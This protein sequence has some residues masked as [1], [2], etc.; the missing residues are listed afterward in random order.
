MKASKIFFLTFGLALGLVLFLSSV[1]ASGLPPEEPI[2][3][4]CSDI[5][6]CSS[7]CTKTCLDDFDGLSTCGA[8]GELCIDS[9][10]CNPCGCSVYRYGTSGPDTIHGGSNNDCIW[11]YED[12]DTLFGEAG[13]D[14][15]Y[16][17]P[18]NDTLFGGSGNDCLYGQG[19]YDYAD[20]GSGH[21]IC[22]AE[23]MVSCND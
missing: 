15:L 13:N 14:I 6:T 7:S 4:Y 19:G 23:T 3:R 8:E 12:A 10:L 1:P 16:G 17:G 11:G 18:G 5:C 22:V 9:V 2:L 20:G 21:D